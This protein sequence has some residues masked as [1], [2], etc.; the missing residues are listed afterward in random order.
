[1]ANLLQS[2]Q[3]KQTIAPDFYTNYLSNLATAGQTAQQNAQ[4]VGAQ[5]LQQKAFEQVNQNFGASQ[6]TMQAAQGLVG[7][8]ANQNITGAAAPYL[9]AGTSTSPLSTMAP[10]AQNAM[11]TTGYDAGM[12]LI[13]QGSGYSGLVAASPFLGR[14]ANVCGA[15]VSGQYVNQAT[16]LN[17]TGAA[18]PYLQQ[19]ATSGGLSAATPYLQ[20]SVGTS[21][22]DLAAQYMNPYLKTAVQGMSDVAQ[23]NI[24]Q[25]LAPAATAAAV[26]SGQF[27]SQRGAQVLG[28]IQAQAQQCLN[29]QIAQMMS[30]GYGQALCAAGKQN[31]LAGQAGQTAVTLAQQQAG[32]LGQLGQTAGSLTAQQQQNL[33]SA[34]NTQGTLTQQ[35]ANLLGQLGSTAGGLTNQTAQ[36]LMSAGTNLGQLQQGA[37]QISAG[38][39]G[40]AANAQQAQ[41]QANLAAAQTASQAAANQGQLY[42]TAGTNLG[43]LG[44]QAAGL[45]LACINALS[46]LGG[47]QQAIGQNQQN[48]PLSTL[49]SLANLLQGY[50]VPVG[51]KTKLEMSPFSALATVGSGAMGLLTPQ[52]DAK[53]NLIPNSANWCKIKNFFG[54]SGG[55]STLPDLST[56]TAP[57][58]PD[59]SEIFNSGTV[60]GTGFGDD[61]AKGGSIKA[62]SNY[63]GCSSTQYRG[64]LPYKRG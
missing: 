12:P 38:L 26:G 34:G 62:R 6:P 2:S 1:M 64:G 58:L 19:A 20:Q 13:A 53:G 41:N 50:S 29:N 48:Y 21:P 35:Q 47:Q 31:A 9:Q 3:C 39:A 5:P 40:T 33:I 59:D 46:T 23:R 51:T 14:A 63:T 54:G 25:N 30:Q 4:F 16:N 8:A 44:A 36:N 22:A 56:V 45:N 27:G 43:A 52:Y 24:Q 28:Q 7:Q 57:Q 15:C 55:T 49:S 11:G 42:N 37:N 17:T 61:L 18:S 32:L 60:P 10:Y